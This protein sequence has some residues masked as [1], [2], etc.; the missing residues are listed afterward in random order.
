MSMTAALYVL[1][2]VMAF[3]S[4]F[5]SG[6]SRPWGG[7]F[8]GMFVVAA[9]LLGEVSCR[10]ASRGHVDAESKTA[11]RGCDVNG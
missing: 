2:L 5:M 11:D 1:L 8:S 10:L 7:V 3:A 6:A 9:Y 4:G